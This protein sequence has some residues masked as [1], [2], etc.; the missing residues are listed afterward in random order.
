[1]DKQVVDLQKDVELKV[2]IHAFEKF[3][4]EINYKIDDLENQSK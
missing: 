4:E 1:M 2:G 3:K